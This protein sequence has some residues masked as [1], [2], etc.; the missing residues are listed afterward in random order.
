MMNI[1]K[2]EGLCRSPVFL[3]LR[4]VRLKW[5]GHVERMNEE[6]QVKRMIDAEIEGRKPVGRP[7]T[8]WKVVIRRDWKSSDLSLEEPESEA[9]DRDRWKNMVHAAGS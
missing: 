2:T 9:R 3:K 6:R 7:G 1:D 5:F 8:R 4:R